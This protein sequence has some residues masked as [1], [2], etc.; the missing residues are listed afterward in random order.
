[1]TLLAKIAFGPLL[2]WQARG[3]RRHAVALPEAA[4][5]REGAVGD[6]RALRLLIVGDS[7]AAGVGAATQDEAL[8]GPLTR[9][10]AAEARRRVGWQLVARSGVS[11]PQ[12]LELLDAHALARADVAV[13][14]LGVNDVVEQLP[15]H[16]ALLARAALV[17]RLRERSGVR[18]AVFAAL[19]PMEQFPLLP[20]P[21]RAVVGR[22]ARR[23]DAAVA[24]WAARRSDASHCPIAIRLGREHMAADGFHPGPAIYRVCGEALAR[25]LVQRVLPTLDPRSAP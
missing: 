14:V 25:H 3:A 9:T 19:P 18:H 6:G 17:D 16:R 5:P 12:A 7:S 21:L 10:L 2:L 15:P 24:A 13:V 20:H 8:A 23:L 22:D 4:G 1:M 11:A